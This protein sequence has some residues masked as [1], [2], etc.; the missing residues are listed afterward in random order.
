MKRM[1][2]L[3]EHIQVKDRQLI[4]LYYS[5]IKCHD[6]LNIWQEGTGGLNV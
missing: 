1:H 2:D 6:F 4:E 3:Q 5:F